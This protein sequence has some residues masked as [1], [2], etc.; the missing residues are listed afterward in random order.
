MSL[1]VIL[2]FEL[3]DG[4]H[5]HH[6]KRERLLS[7]HTLTHTDYLHALIHRIDN[8]TQ[9][10]EDSAGKQP[11]SDVLYTVNR[12]STGFFPINQ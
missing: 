10:H 3:M 6:R 4:Y 11:V 2:L 1:L 12:I 8:D 9:Q 5:P 7:S